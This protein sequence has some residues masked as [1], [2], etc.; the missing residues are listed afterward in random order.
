M[1]PARAAVAS[2]TILV[3]ARLISLRQ[4]DNRKVHAGRCA[5]H[6]PASG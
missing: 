3:R 6:T 1:F 4:K 5:N 2:A